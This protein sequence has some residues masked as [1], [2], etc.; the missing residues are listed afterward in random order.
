LCLALAPLL[1]EVTLGH[2]NWWEE[3][4]LLRPWEPL[5][6]PVSTACAIFSAQLFMI[7]VSI[8]KPAKRPWVIPAT[9]P[10]SCTSEAATDALHPI[11]PSRR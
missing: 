7:S 9:Q 10:V 1:A 5:A 11:A 4:V 2:P 6:G 8:E 3:V